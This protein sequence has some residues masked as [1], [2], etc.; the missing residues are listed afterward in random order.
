VVVE[1]TMDIL[2]VYEWR[3]DQPCD[4]PYPLSCPILYFNLFHIP[5]PTSISPSVRVDSTRLIRF[6]HGN[7]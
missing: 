5:F 2:V 7:Y 6:T 3:D 4:C 1:S